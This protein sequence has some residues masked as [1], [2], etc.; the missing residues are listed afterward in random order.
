VNLFDRVRN[1]PAVSTEREGNSN[2]IYVSTFGLSPSYADTIRGIPGSLHK[3]DI[4]NGLL[5]VIFNFESIEF[6]EDY[7]HLHAYDAYDQDFIETDS[8]V[9]DEA[10]YRI[11][12]QNGFWSSPVLK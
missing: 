9:C 4:L 7:D 10:Q 6:D 3:I 1:C 2:S 8:V 5:T 12:G 11:G